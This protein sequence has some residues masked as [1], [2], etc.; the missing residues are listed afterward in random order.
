MYFMLIMPIEHRHSYDQKFTL[1][2]IF[3]IL[4]S[5]MYKQSKTTLM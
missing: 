4:H 3:V 2:F 5:T 1:T